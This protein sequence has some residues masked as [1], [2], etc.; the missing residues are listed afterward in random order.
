MRSRL[1]GSDSRSGDPLELEGYTVDQ[2]SH[3]SLGL[4]NSLAPWLIQVL[5]HNDQTELG[6]SSPQ[7]LN[8]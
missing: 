8:V 3:V 1:L 4:S 5:L 2:S 7:G 6:L